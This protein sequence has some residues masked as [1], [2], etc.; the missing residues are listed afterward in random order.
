MPNLWTQFKALT[1]N[2]AVTAG[3]ITS[4]DGQTSTVE[5][6]S[7]DSVKVRGTGSVG[8]IAYMQRGE[9]VETTGTLQQFN[10]IL[11]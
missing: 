10:L 6:L 3:T 5:L 1:D 4:T 8:Q 11:Y 2:D 7:G 9:I